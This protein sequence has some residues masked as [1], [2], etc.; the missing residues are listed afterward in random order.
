MRNHLV[1]MAKKPVAGAVKSRLAAEIGV[2]EATRFYRVTLGR[3][4]RRL[5]DDPRWRT[6]LAVAPD[7][8]LDDLSWPRRQPRIPQGDGDLGMRMQ[9]VFDRLPP[10]PVVIV[11][12]DIPGL[13]S[14]H[15]ASAFTAL[16]R[17]DV[18]LGPAE[19]GGYWL[20]GLRRRPRVPRIF[21]GVRW[22]SAA[23]LSDTLD[24]CS[25]LDVALLSVLADVD[26]GKDWR[27]W[28]REGVSS[29]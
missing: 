11:G 10:G 28:R 3:L 14:E 2:A 7:R 24:N 26:T 20:V 27:R 21:A 8:A 16:G 17:H 18:A 15:V 5:T 9:R 23:A 22:S 6:L 25:G 4:L 29:R 12:S 1:V 13:G 19:D